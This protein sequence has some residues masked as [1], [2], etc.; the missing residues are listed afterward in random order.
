MKKFTNLPANLPAVEVRNIT[1]RSFQHLKTAFESAYLMDGFLCLKFKITTEKEG[2][3]V[4]DERM[5]S[6]KG[7][8][9]LSLSDFAVGKNSSATLYVLRK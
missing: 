5:F 6:R 9:A 2:G 4:L 1:D 8:I 7:D 3:F